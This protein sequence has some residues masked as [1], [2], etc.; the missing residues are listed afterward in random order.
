MTKEALVKV[1]DNLPEEF[2]LDEFLEKLIIIAKIEKGRQQI[3]E[4]KGISLEE[5]IKISKTWSK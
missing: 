5:A 3:K 1:V 4:G 2:E